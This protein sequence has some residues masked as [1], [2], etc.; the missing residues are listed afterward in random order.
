MFTGKIK[1]IALFLCLQN[2]YATDTPPN[3]DYW[4]PNRLDLSPL[5][6]HD[7]FNP[8][9]KNQTY[10]QN[11]E[12]LDLDAL[13]A[14]LKKMM[15]TSQDW[16]PADY[17]TYAPFFIRMAWHSAGTYRTTDGRGGADGGMQRF[18]PL[19]SWP[20]NANLDK[21]RRLLWPIKQKYGNQISW[22][23]L[24]VLTGDVALESMGFKTIG[25]AG[26]RIDAWESDNVD[27]GTERTW[28]ASNRENAKGQIKK[29]YGASQM[30]LIYV[31][32]E[33]PNGKPDPVAAAAHIRQTFGR[34]AMND[35]ETVALIAGGHAFGKAHGAASAKQ[36]LGPNPEAS[37][38][39]DQGFG[40]KN[41]YQTGKGPDTITSGLEGAWSPTPTRWSNSYL[42]NLFHFKWVATKSPSGATQWIPD[43]KNAANLVPDAYDA[44]KRH[45]PMMFTTDLA[46]R[47]DPS[48]RKI[49]ERFL[50]H[51]DE[52]QT[53]FA[54]AWFK[55][56]HRDM[57]PRSRYLGKLVPKE[58]FIWQDPVPVANYQM[59]NDTDI[60]ALKDKI[61]HSGLTNAEMIRVAW[62]SAST[63]RQTDMRGGA[64]G[65]RIQLEP[66]K[67][68]E[69]NDPSELNKVL[70]QLK[71]IQN[72]FNQSSSPRKISL[73]DLIVLAGS[74]AI[75]QAII[76][77]GHQEK[78][79]FTPGRTDATQ[80]MT[81]VSSFAVLKP[82][83]DG[84]RNYYQ[85]QETKPEE[86]LVE[87]ASMLNLSVPEMTAL[88]GGM[89][90]LNANYKQ[91]T[92]GVLTQT[93]GKLSNDFFVNLLDMSTVWKKSQEKGIYEGFDRTTGQLKWKATDVDLI[94]GS[95]SELRAVAEFYAQS[96]NQDKFI[97]DFVKA[98]V[99]VM[100]LDRF[101]IKNA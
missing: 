97:Q 29:P 86:M 66:Q 16:W 18:A 26:G 31:N 6:N 51:P 55:L 91:S 60:S 87:K 9:D 35:E 67:S 72:E 57:G 25:F 58:V 53:A 1:F 50:K 3:N 92:L 40:W 84:F 95:Q 2:T 39:E 69:I 71:K 64:N 47:Y 56:M 5:K 4:W 81:D 42:E 45:A 59:V 30:G 49:S 101:D 21:A 74:T 28:L 22:S 78:V 23:D 83:A 12:K 20:D 99:K 52:L 19:N 8:N 7:S 68:W 38:I 90:V 100:N 80:N 15:V 44:K 36:Y 70:V 14:D 54:K 11:F 34:M 89:R 85:T 96:D 37:P 62:A 77:S 43:D 82:Q 32:P 94:F 65:A 46:L 41:T 98:W 48:Y 73:A 27:W 13:V 76:Q 17:G 24:M 10:A 33:G 88:I 79:P 61:I 75:E 63:F 93:P